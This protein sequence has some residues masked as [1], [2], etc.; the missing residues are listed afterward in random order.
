[1]I[2]KIGQLA[3]SVRFWI[4]VLSAIVAVLNGSPLLD[5]IQV[6]LAA[7]VGIGTLDSVGKSFAGRK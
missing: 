4:V 5:T 7:V 6:A 1:M 2:Q 3:G